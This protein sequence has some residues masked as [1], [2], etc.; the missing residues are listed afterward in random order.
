MTKVRALNFVLLIIAIIFGK[1][2][3][4]K[5]TINC[6]TIFLIIVCF[7][8]DS[9]DENVLLQNYKFFFYCCNSILKS[10]S[11]CSFCNSIFNLSLGKIL[12][13]APVSFLFRL[14]RP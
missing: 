13:F 2:N 5:Q 14:W 11:E 3:V 4:N 12:Y 9:F 6:Y 10:D 1:I 8:L 7:I